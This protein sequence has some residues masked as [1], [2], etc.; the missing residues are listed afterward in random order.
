[1][2][3]KYNE[4]GHRVTDCCGADSAY[5][6]KDEGRAVLR[7]RACWKEVTIGEGDGK[8]ALFFHVPRRQHIRDVDL[9]TVP[10]H[11]TQGDK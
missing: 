1:M 4:W 3:K 11:M 2:V 9:L 10:Q 8:E 6:P 7:C 5:R